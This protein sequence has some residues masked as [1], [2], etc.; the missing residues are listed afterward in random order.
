[1][2]LKLSRHSWECRGTSQYFF[3]LPSLAIK[4]F[5]LDQIK[6]HAFSLG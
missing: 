2:H 6:L 4:L 3:L 1:M 5:G